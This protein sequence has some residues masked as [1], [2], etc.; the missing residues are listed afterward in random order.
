MLNESSI[1]KKQ[2]ILCVAIVL[3]VA[4]YILNGLAYLSGLTNL[5]Q[6]FIP[7]VVLFYPMLILTFVCLV[8]QL[9]SV[10]R[11][12]RACGGKLRLI[13][14]GLVVVSTTA[15]VG[16]AVFYRPWWVRHTE[17]LRVRV[18]RIE[19]Q[20]ELGVIRE[21]LAQFEKT[22]DGSYPQLIPLESCPTP[23]KDLGGHTVWISTNGNGT[24]ETVSVLWG[25]AFLGAWG[26]TIGPPNMEIPESSEDEYILSWVPGAYFWHS[27]R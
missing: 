3:I 1:V 10:V 11:A 21:W 4:L 15:L 22:E 17:G 25:G 8:Y 9:Y 26:V 7:L 27:S 14:V 19:L 16:G 5:D 12:W 23:I 20:G 24:I 6:L 18:N 13:Q 2:S